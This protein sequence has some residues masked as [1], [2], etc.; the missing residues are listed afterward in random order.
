MQWIFILL[1]AIIFSSLSNPSEWTQSY[2]SD[3]GRFSLHRADT[4][5][6]RYRT[7]LAYLP[8]N[9][10]LYC[11]VL[12]QCPYFLPVPFYFFD[13]KNSDTN[14][15]PFAPQTGGE[16]LRL[17]YIFNLLSNNVWENEIY[18]QN[19]RLIVDREQKKNRQIV[20]TNGRLKVK[21]LSGTRF[22][23]F[24]VKSNDQFV[25][26]A[27]KSFTFS[28][29]FSLR[30]ATQYIPILSVQFQHTITWKLQSDSEI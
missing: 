4:C 9:Y 19:Y 6:R 14:S 23:R 11:A 20:E 15:V 1:W 10:L 7:H 5:W 25:V 22:V 8:S 18:L 13:H 12:L 21:A 16:M 30:Q 26:F 17:R 2:Y 29:Y 3:F 27:C 24:V 28:A